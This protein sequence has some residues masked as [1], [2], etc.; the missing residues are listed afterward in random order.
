MADLNLYSVETAFARVLGRLREIAD[1]FLYLLRLHFLGAFPEE[2]VGRGRGAPHRSPGEAAVTLYPV[3]VELRENFR[4]I[5]MNDRSELL[6]AGNN[7]GIEGEHQPL[8][9]MIGGMHG[10]LFGHDQARSPLARSR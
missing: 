7:F 8:V 6:I 10:Q 4:L 1:E 2:R 5:L 9:G 3:M